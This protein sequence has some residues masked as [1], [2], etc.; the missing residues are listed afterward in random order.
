MEIFNNNKFLTGHKETV[1]D[2]NL[3]DSSKTNIKLF[4][5]SILF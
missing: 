1:L 5:N 4:F 3:T 2:N